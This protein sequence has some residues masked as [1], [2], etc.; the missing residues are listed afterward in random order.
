MSGLKK[1]NPQTLRN[2]LVLIIVSIIGIVTVVYVNY[3][4]IS[5]N[6]E[7]LIT[8]FKPGVDMTIDE[9]HQTAT[10]NGRKEWQLD[11]TSAQ[12]IDSQ[13]KV[14]LDNLGMIFFL[15][16]QQQVQLT[17]DSGTLETE[18]QN[19]SVKGQVELRNKDALL[20]TDELHY[21][22]AK[23][24][25]FSETPVTISGDD[26]QLSAERMTLDLSK[27]KAVLKGSV[28][29]TFNEDISL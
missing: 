22:H 23:R 6:P 19:V 1:K 5:A 12:Y 20:N 8:I 27:R 14:R 21:R 11:A 7:K 15:E 25:I 28:R 18:S 16:D 3:R 10:R 29:V 4:K 26:F 9:I 13:K 2:V 17:A 24:F